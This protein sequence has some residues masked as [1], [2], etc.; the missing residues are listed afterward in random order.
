MAEILVQENAVHIDDT[1]MAA[2]LES[3]FENG[4]S[5]EAVKQSTW[6]KAAWWV[7][8][9]VWVGGDLSHMTFDKTLEDVAKKLRKHYKDRDKAPPARIDL[10]DESDNPIAS[11]EIEEDDPPS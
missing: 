5:A 3:L 11:L 6:P 9:L 4:L 1:D 10:V 2:I 7:L 8:V